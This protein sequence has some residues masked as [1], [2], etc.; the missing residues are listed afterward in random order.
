MSKKL[1]YDTALAELNQILTTLQSDDTGL[2]QISMLV[3]RAAEL[4]TFCK[5]KLREIEENI[6][7][8]SP[9]D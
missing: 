2:D 4:S 9:S 8:I 3:K 6:E 7:K 5:T 1:T